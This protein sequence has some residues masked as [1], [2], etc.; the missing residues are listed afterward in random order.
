MFWFTSDTHYGHNNIIKYS[1]RPFQHGGEMNEALIAN[2]NS[3]VGKSDTVYHLGDFA[4]CHPRR[5]TEIAYALNGT[6]H[7]IL[8]NHDKQ[9]NGEFAKRFASISHYA[10]IKLGEH[11]TVLCH[12]P[13]HSWNKSHHGSLHC[14]GHTHGSVPNMG[15]RRLDVGVDTNNYF[16]YSDEEVIKLLTAIPLTKDREYKNNAE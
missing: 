6:I 15:R 11:K 12:F 3:R 10:E 9:V 14:H 8:G 5:R 16:P 2:F 1:G 13:F 4:L 7:L